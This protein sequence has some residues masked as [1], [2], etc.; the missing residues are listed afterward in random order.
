MGLE[1]S[2]TI[3]LKTVYLKRKMLTDSESN[4]HGLYLLLTKDISRSW[5]NARKLKKNL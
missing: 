5:Q 2:E 1:Y 3:P 4:K